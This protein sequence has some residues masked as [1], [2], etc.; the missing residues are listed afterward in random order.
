MSSHRTI[1]EKGVESQAEASPATIV[2]GGRPGA[3]TS[4]ATIVEPRGNGSETQ[5]LNLVPGAEFRSYRLEQPMKVA[6]AE[7][8]LWRVERRADGARFVLKL[9]RYGLHPKS[10]ILEALQRLRREHIV[11][12]VEIGEVDERSYEIQEFVEKGSLADVLKRGAVSEAQARNIVSELTDSLAHLHEAHVL[13]RDIKPSNILVRSLDPVDL[14]LTDFGISSLSEN[15]LHLTNVNRTAAYCAPEA[16]TGVVAR[17]SDWWSVGVVAIELLTGKHPLAGLSDQVINFQLVSKG[18][19][20]PAE[21]PAVWQPLLKGLLTRDHDKRWG[22]EQV[23]AWLAGRLDIPVHFTGETATTADGR[24]PYKF[25]NRDFLELRELGAALAQK[26]NEAVKH[27]SWGFLQQWVETEMGDEYVAGSLLD[28][29]NNLQLTADEKAAITILLLN[30]ELPLIFKGQIVDWNWC[31]QNVPAALALTKSPALAWFQRLDKESCLVAW[32]A[33]RDARRK[34][35]D[36]FGI[37]LD[38]SVVERLLCSPETSVISAACEQRRLFACASHAAL[39]PLLRQP[40]LTFAQAAVLLACDR[41]LLLTAAQQ[42]HQDKL[43]RLR[44][45]GVELN[46]QLAEKLVATENWDLLRPLW[47]ETL[48]LWRRRQLLW[49][50]LSNPALAEILNNAAPDYFDAVA[51]VA[52]HLDFVN[53]LGMRFLS[54][55]SLTVLFAAWPTRVQDYEAFA[56]ATARAWKAPAYPQMPTHPAV[57]VSW[58]D[59]SAFCQWLTH[60]E[61]EQGRIGKSDEYRLVYDVEWS[62]AVGLADEGGTLPIH[63]AGKVQGIFPWGTQW[64]PPANAGN[65]AAAVRCDNFTHTSP[66]GSFAANERGI[67]DLGTNVTEWCWDW[68]DPGQQLKTLRGASWFQSTPDALWS[69]VRRFFVPTAKSD[70]IGFRCA[71]VVRTLRASQAESPPV[72]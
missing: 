34:E 61:R 72:S 7:A 57:N 40:S 3:A 25:D 45:F 36:Q 22:A 60:K 38:P 56:K 51:V 58:E 54:V 5:F 63:R 21:T 1:I 35:I 11:E 29:C 19:P 66:V 64:P 62:R 18:I 71:L 8:D 33:Q 17:A 15:S 6:S 55:P 41:T 53:S 26:W 31:Q 43:E 9:Y 4:A 12:L 30:P 68:Y 16:L 65:I 20:I 24:K 52:N 48:T 44:A 59:A 47:E 50:P 28:V 23:R 49:L 2:E 70:S 10:E 39:E 27:S 69:S 13:H 67:Y 32:A 42:S 14:I 46:V 37:P